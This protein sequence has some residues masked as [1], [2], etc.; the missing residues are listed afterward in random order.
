MKKK[1]FPGIPSKR[2]GQSLVEMGLFLM[3]LM[4]LLA[5]AV[6]FGIAYFSYVT[7]RDAAQEGVIFGSVNPQLDQ[8][9]FKSNVE[10]RVIISADRP[11]GSNPIMHSGSTI[12]NVCPPPGAGICSSGTS[13]TV[14]L[15]NEFTVQV[16]YN[17]PLT[18]PFLSLIIGNNNIMLTARATGVI[19]TNP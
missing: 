6:D 13:L 11:T 7:I 18:V 17:Y 5:G 10:A 2:R 8:A 4:W 16:Q 1:R 12:V 3:I 19:L 14:A 15:G 9:I